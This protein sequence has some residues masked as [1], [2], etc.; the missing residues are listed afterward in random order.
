[1][2]DTSIFFFLYRLERLGVVGADGGGIVDAA[3]LYRGIKKPPI[4]PHEK[5]ATSWRIRGRHARVLI[6]PEKAKP[7]VHEF[8]IQKRSSARRVG[9]SCRRSRSLM[10]NE[11]GQFQN[12]RKALLLT[13][14]HARATRDDIKSA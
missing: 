5:K 11:A 8:Q 10:G 6:P 7:P 4:M 12:R 13:L 3:A 1:M 9:G 14:P 2:G